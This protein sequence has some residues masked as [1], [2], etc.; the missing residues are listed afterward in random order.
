MLKLALELIKI[1]FERH[2][3]DSCLVA[4]FFHTFCI[5][6]RTQEYLF[7]KCKP[8]I[9]E[10]ILYHLQKAKVHV[11]DV[12]NSEP[13]LMYLLRE[14]V[15]KKLDNLL[16]LLKYD[17]GNI[18]PFLDNEGLKELASEVRLHRRPLFWES[19]RRVKV[20]VI[21]DAKLLK[22]REV[23]ILEVVLSFLDHIIG[24][25]SF[26]TYCKILRF[27]WRSIPDAYIS[28]EEMRH[29]PLVLQG[30]CDKCVE[31]II[32]EIQKRDFENFTAIPQPR[33][34][35]HYSR[36]TIRRAL[37]CNLQLPQGIEQLG[38]HRR[39]QSYLKIEY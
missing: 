17:S 6:Y 30:E 15:E 38:L 21:A 25:P 2:D 26:E 36:C 29:V 7:F 18:Y 11:N 9:T 39:M 4:E 37:N 1:F 32:E 10:Y 24:A 34:L 14:I 19:C 13:R 12:F 35:M 31:D 20:A 22:N 8:Q 5:S 33:S 28:Y 23:Y 27:I 16:L 3:Q